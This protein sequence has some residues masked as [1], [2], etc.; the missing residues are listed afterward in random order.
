[1]AKGVG[2]RGSRPTWGRLGRRIFACVAGAALLPAAP[3]LAS[4]TIT[5]VAGGGTRTDDGAGATL[6][7]LKTPAGVRPVAN[8]F[9]VAEQGRYRV[10]R[11]SI[12]DISTADTGAI[13]TIAGSGS[14]GNGQA[15][16][17]GAAT[18]VSMNLPCCLSTTPNGDLLVADTLG[19]MVWRVAGSRIRTVAGSG[20]PTSCPPSPPA[21]IAAQ[22]ASLCFVVGVGAAPGEDRFLVAEDGLPDQGRSGGARVYEVDPTGVLHIVAGGGCPN[23]SPG[24]GPLGICLANPR[25]PLYTGNPAAPTEFV[26]ADRGRNVIWKISSTNAATATA[27]LIA[28]T[29]RATASDLSDL[30][31]A[32]PA[33]QATLSGPSDLAV[34]PNGNLLVADRDN[35]RVRRIAALSAA[36]TITTLAGTTCTA[37]GYTGD[38]GPAMLAGLAYPQGVAFSPAGILISESIGGRVRLVQ[39]TSITEGPA[40][41]VTSAAATFDFE[42]AQSAPQFKCAL[43]GDASVAPCTSPLTYAHLADGV[44]TFSVFDGAPPADPSPAR[45]SWVIDTTPPEPLK[46]GAP[47]AGAA[48]L[49]PRPAFTWSAAPD[50]TTGIDRYELVVDRATYGTLQPG[51]CA[52]GVCSARPSGELAEG[53]HTWSVR[54]FDRVGLVR[55]SESRTIA[56]GSDPVA[57]LAV[58]PDPVLVGNPVGI[59]ASTSRDEGGPIAR[60]EW[61]LD[62]DGVFEIDTGA[63][64]FVSRS[65]PLAGVVRLSV[66]A[67]DGA[68]RTAVAGRTLRVNNPPGAPRLYGVSVNSGADYAS[69]PDVTL[70]LVYPES[71]TGVVMSNDGGFL[72]AMALGPSAKLRWRLASSGPERLPK[73]VYVRFMSGPFVTDSYSDDIILDETR[74]L[75]VGAS[76]RGASAARV[77]DVGARSRRLV[78]VSARDN[79]SGVAG[80]QISVGRRDKAKRFRPYSRNSVLVRGSGKIWVRVRDRAGNVSPWREAS[81]A[82]ATGARGSFR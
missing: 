45:R 41:D 22:S 47:E 20:A 28:G 66:R 50:A 32:G 30:G 7:S 74:P 56:V 65:F 67:T 8:G 9:L 53:P 29:A 25:G 52:G 60:Y 17:D 75:V 11:V 1:M 59:D 77:G 71:T 79:A 55:D 72:T 15:V 18:A 40:G 16:L 80:V 42:S 6:S 19:G 4:T 31:D 38:D 27:S 73:T 14:P 46:L 82:S 5:T 76:V 36:S 21:E 44:H 12:A 13:A 24:A 81:P 39:R 68:G 64:P 63:R 33:G 37:A 26:V 49:E 61:D 62:G 69:S 23:P 48:D 43:D 3:G 78:H 35:C 58:A 34:A 10:R 54:A 57:R 70:N 51:D 2:R